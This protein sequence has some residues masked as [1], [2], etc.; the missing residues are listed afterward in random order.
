MIKKDEWIVFCSPFEDKKALNYR[1]G[2]LKGHKNGSCDIYVKAEDKT[3]ESV[4]E[5]D[6]NKLPSLAAFLRVSAYKL[7]GR[8]DVLKKIAVAAGRSFD[9]NARDSYGN[10]VLHIPE[11]IRERDLVEAALS[12]GARTYKN[13]YGD[14]PENIAEK[15]GLD[16][17]NLGEEKY[18]AICDDKCGVRGTIC[19]KCGRF[20]ELGSAFC[21]WC[22]DFVD[23][24]RGLSA[25]PDYDVKKIMDLCPRCGF[26]VRQEHYFC[27]T[28]GYTLK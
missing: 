8:D 9:V 12:L 21:P 5:R 14:Y 25:Y 27:G 15:L 19:R 16:K 22:R 10:T 1:L 11:I 20:V 17:G 24:K 26:P 7:K 28:C 2:R 3:Y 18:R 6:I 23:E 4:P 13:V